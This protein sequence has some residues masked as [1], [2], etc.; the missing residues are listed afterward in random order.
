[1][2]DICFSQVESVRILTESGPVS[3]NAGRVYLYLFVFH[4]RTGR[5]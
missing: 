4:M 5:G 3:E 1:M 2:G